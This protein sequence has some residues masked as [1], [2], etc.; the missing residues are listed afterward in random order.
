MVWEGTKAVCQIDGQNANN[1]L[2]KALSNKIMG[3]SMKRFLV[4]KYGWSNATFE[5]IAWNAH[6]KELQAYP[7]TRKVT[8]IKYMHGWLAT[9]KRRHQEGR[10][11]DPLCPLCGVEETKRHFFHCQNPQM[12]QINKIWWKQYLRDIGD[13]TDNGRK[14]VFQVGLE[15]L[16]GGESQ[17]IREKREWPRDLQLAFQAQ[18]E[19]GWDQVLSGRIAK[20]WETQE[21]HKTKDSSRVPS[22]RWIR[23]IIRL[24]WDYGLEIWKTRNELVHGTEGHI[25][26]ME[27]SQ[28]TMLVRTMYRELRPLIQ[29]RRE[30]IFS[31]GEKIRLEQNCSSQIAWQQQLRFL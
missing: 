28:T 23:K 20:Q 5:S 27:Q 1:E 25:S 15:T 14:H 7:I 13:D 26:K 18:E 4:Q 31:V 29:H 16:L 21:V 11:S 10:F 24:S 3:I 12:R 6:E 19:I 30:E 22:N 9:K 17:P 8:L 2:F